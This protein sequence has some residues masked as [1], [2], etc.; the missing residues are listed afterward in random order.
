M[1][2]NIAQAE[3]PEERAKIQNSF[4]ESGQQSFDILFLG[5]LSNVVG[6]ATVHVLQ[7]NVNVVLDKKLGHL[8][9]SKDMKI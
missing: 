2:T 1:F 8:E 9:M 5:Q 7:M 4:E 3:Q 6:G